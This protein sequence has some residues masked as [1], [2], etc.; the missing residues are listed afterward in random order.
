MIKRFIAGVAMC[1]VLPAF[2]ATNLVADG[3]F[4]GAGVAAGAYDTFSGSDLPGWLALPGDSIEVRNGL[5]GSAQEGV[6]FV[7]LD[8]TH[9]SSMLTSFGTLAGQTYALS[10]YYSGR[11]FSADDNPA[12]AG[13]VVPG[14]SDGLSVSVGGT[15]VNLVSATNTTLDNVWTLYTATFVGTGKSMSLL[16]AATGDNDSYGASL[17]NVSVTAVPEPATLAMMAAGV[18]GL[19]GLGRRRGRGR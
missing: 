15:T 3:S 16:F 4:E 13:G 18:L 2:A 5:V 19:L 12:V 17:D 10:F 1:S 8:S 14:S 7:E 11:A 9:N 6:D